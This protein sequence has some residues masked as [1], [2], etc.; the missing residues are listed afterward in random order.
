MIES[1][2]KHA[3]EAE[4]L[5]KR[6]LELQEKSLGRDHIN[7]V[8]MLD[9]LADVCVEQAKYADAE[10]LYLR[11]IAIHERK[12]ADENLALAETAEKYAA[13]LRRVNRT[14]DAD[15]WHARALAI[16]DLAA[17]KAAKAKA[18]RVQQD[19]QGFK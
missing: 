7:S 11:S 4:R 17:T 2:L 12:P 9:Q 3:A 1:A 16:R 6:S 13:L 15:R 14:A 18:D 5:F 19:F 10:Q 8:V